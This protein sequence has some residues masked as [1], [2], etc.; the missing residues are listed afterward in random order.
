MAEIVDNPLVRKFSEFRTKEGRTFSA[1]HHPSFWACT[2]SQFAPHSENNI[3]FNMLGVPSDYSFRTGKYLFYNLS[4]CAIVM[5][6][7]CKPIG[8]HITR[9]G[10]DHPFKIFVRRG[11][12]HLISMNFALIENWN[13]PVFGLSREFEKFLKNLPGND[14]D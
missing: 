4:E 1:A 9:L 5:P 12:A 10:E 2:N 8:D 7:I 11:V 14:P 13:A 3:L 6:I